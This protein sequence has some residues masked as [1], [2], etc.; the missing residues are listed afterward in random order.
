MGSGSFI[1]WIMDDYFVLVE[2][3]EC[4]TYIEPIEKI[5]NESS[6]VSLNGNLFG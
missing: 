1:G 2:A 3:S 4:I 6:R 5:R